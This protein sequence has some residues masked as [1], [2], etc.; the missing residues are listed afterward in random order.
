MAIEM[1]QP[2]EKSVLIVEDERDIAQLL[3]LHLSEFC[4]QVV[5]AEDGIEGLRLGI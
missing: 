4:Q 2:G 5:L 1:T 3:Q